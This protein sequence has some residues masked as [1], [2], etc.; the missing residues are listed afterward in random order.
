MSEKPY[1]AG[2]VMQALKCITLQ[3]MHYG[4]VF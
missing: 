1:G 4:K 3:I 2:Y